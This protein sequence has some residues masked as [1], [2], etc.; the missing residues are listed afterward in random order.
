L[1]MA[2]LSGAENKNAFRVKAAEEF[3]NAQK[4]A[5]LVL[6]ADAYSTGEQTKAPFGKLNPNEYNVLPV[7][8]VLSNKSNVVLRLSKMRVSYVSGRQTVEAT[9]AADVPF[10]N[11]PDRPKVSVHP[12]P[13]IGRAKKNPLAAPEIESRSFAAKMLA[14]G[15]SAHG[16]FYFHLTHRPDSTLYVTGIEEAATGKELF[17]VE[18]PLGK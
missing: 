7:L 10:L 6:A 14:P 4:V 9:P 16:F 8:L 15:E 12:I 2:A 18:I 1:L 5:G 13:R 11:A 17:F 3:P